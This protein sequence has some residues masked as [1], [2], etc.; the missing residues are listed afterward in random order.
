MKQNKM[1]SDMVKRVTETP[2]GL[3]RMLMIQSVSIILRIAGAEA[4]RFLR[5]ASENNCG[6]I[7]NCCTKFLGGWNSEW[8]LG[9][10]PWPA[11]L[12][13]PGYC[14]SFLLVWSPAG[15]T[16][17]ECRRRFSWE[18]M[19]ICPASALNFHSHYCLRVIIPIVISSLQSSW[20]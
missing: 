20:L 5:D 8:Q 18:L 13:S 19:F 9:P 2:M 7:N 10:Q 3:G 1:W 6:F 12:Q 17:V 16:D 14:L 15:L 11:E 4:P